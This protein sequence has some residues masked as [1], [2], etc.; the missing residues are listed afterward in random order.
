VTATYG[1]GKTNLYV[2]GQPVGS[3]TYDGPF[4][5]KPGTPLYLASDL[6][7]GSYKG[8]NAGLTAKVYNRALAADEIR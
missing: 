1:N 7:D 2:N 3:N 4:A 5:I 6:P 8:A